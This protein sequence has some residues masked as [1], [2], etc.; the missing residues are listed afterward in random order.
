MH[1]LPFTS[2]LLIASSTLPWLILALMHYRKN[3]N[4]GD[5]L[6]SDS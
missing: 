2:W 3:A 1:E 6:P 4:S 5:R